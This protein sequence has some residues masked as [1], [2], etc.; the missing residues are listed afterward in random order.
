MLHAELTVAETLSYAAKLRLP[1]TTTDEE[2][3]DREKEVL[4]FMGITHVAKVI[5]GD[6]R[7]KGGSPLF[8][9]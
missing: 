5:V 3:T 4:G 8:S 7:R 6:S 9:I 1:P 2:R